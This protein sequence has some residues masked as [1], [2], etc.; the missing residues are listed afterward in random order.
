[1]KLFNCDV[2]DGLKRLDDDSVDCI[3]IFSNT[4][5]KYRC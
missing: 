5:L 3:V 2:L 1:M 4:L